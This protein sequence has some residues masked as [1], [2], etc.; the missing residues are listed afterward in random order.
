MNTLI[1]IELS[2][3]QEKKYKEWLNSLEERYA[4]A[5]GGAY[6]YEITPTGLG[7]VIKVYY[8]KDTKHEKS[9]DLTEYDLW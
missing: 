2:P 3:E 8:F 4:G 6:T 5:I 7:V 9:I 1:K